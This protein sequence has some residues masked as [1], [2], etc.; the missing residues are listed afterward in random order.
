MAQLRVTKLWDQAGAH[1][2][3]PKER[4]GGVDVTER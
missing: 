2:A 4:G 1:Q 3:A